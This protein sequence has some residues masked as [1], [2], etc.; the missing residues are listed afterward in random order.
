[1]ARPLI[2]LALFTIVLGCQ[3]GPRPGP[4]LLATY[5][6]DGGIAGNNQ[7][8]VVHETGALALDDRR[9]G[10][11]YRTSVDPGSLDR[12]RALLASPEFVAAQRQ[13]RVEGG[14]DPITYTVEGRAP[15]R[16]HTVTTMDSAAHPRVVQQAIEELDR[17]A[18]LAVE[19]GGP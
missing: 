16:V 10:R 3:S 14:A 11:V 8:L 13:Y 19:R 17:L 6:K 9:A 1:M 12:L 5:Q 7:R 4:S 15:G 2:S 18:Q